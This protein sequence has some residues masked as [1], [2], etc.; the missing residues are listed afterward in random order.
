M[1]FFIILTFLCQ[2]YKTT[3]FISNFRPV[4]GREAVAFGLI[5][6]FFCMNNF[7]T[8]PGLQSLRRIPHSNKEAAYTI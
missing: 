7:K 2:S 5:P 4:I 6:A 8:N 3:S 1:N